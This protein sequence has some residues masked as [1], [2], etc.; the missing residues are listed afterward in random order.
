[1]QGDDRAHIEL[2]SPA[3]DFE[4]L[5]AAVQ[6]GADA[7]YFGVGRLNMRVSSTKNFLPSDL[8]EIRR[9]CN[10]HKLKA[11]LTLNT[12]V[13]DDD[14]E[15]LKEMVRIAKENHI[16]AV[17]ASDFSVIQYTREL[18]I[19]LHI[20]TQANIS[21]FEALKFFA[22]YG[23]VVV[24]ARELSLDQVREICEQARSAGLHGPSGKPLRIEA[25]IHG[26]L[27]MSI[28]GKCYLSLHEMN[29]SA[30]RG[31]CM[32]LCRRAYILTEKDDGYQIDVDNEYLMSPKDLCTIR[33]IDKI[34]EAGVRVLKIEGRGRSPEYVKLVTAS[35]REAIDDW[36]NGLVSPD[37]LERLENKLR[38]VYNRGFWEGYYMGK[39]TGEWSDRYGSSATRRKVYIG[40]SLNYFQHVGVAEFRIE[41]G[42]LEIGD[43]IMIIG[44]TSG[45]I[46]EK[47]R[48]IRVDDG[49]VTK[50]E[51][52]VN[53]SI[54]V[55]STV[56]RSDKLYKWIQATDEGTS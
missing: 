8:P 51:K 38:S 6:S 33:F 37:K 42:M 47:V 56:R 18:N 46:E 35:Y 16:D 43:E 25:F 28:S 23:D 13:Y 31:E 9:I 15:E 27:C 14:L 36:K 1:M 49:P 7:V 29:K 17:I 5:M 20:S 30:N 48:E 32:Q 40:K 39:K 26:A 4:S 44:P 54:P 24:L 50:A 22:E 41:T 3:G 2:L 21:N 45:V 53:C 11:C 52:G 10:E 55:G 19:P 12:V 34:L